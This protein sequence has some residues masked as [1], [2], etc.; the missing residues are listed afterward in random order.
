METVRNT[1]IMTFNT[2]NQRQRTL[3]VPDP[4]SDLNESIVIAAA[5]DIVESDVFAENSITGVPASLHRADLQ[6]VR[7]VVLF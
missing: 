5:Q 6:E 2:S 7:S 3:S 1:L 4:I